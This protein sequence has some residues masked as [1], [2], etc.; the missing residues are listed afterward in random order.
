MVK[1]AE[2]PAQVGEQRR[3]AGVARE[4]QRDR[5]A[6]GLGLQHEAAPQC[7]AAVPRCSARPVVRR[8]EV[9]LHRAGGPWHDMPLPPVHAP[10]PG[11]AR[12]GHPAFD[13]Q[14]NDEQGRTAR[15]AG[16]R[17]HGSG[18]E[19]VVV[20]VADQD[21]VD[22]WQ[23]LD[24]QGCGRQPARTREG[25]RRG[26]R[27]EVRIGEDVEPRHLPQRGGVPEPGDRQV[28]PVAAQQIDVG[29]H[30][31]H[32]LRPVG[33]QIGLQP[34]P[35]PAQEAALL[36]AMGRGVQVDEAPGPM[37]RL[38]GIERVMGRR[39]SGQHDHQQR[40]QARKPPT[41]GCGGKERG[42]RGHGDLE[43]T[44][45]ALLSISAGSPPSDPGGKTRVHQFGVRAHT[46]DSNSPLHSLT[47]S[48]RG[49]TSPVAPTPHARAVSREVV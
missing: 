47:V 9:H 27:T 34:L 5:R 33:R 1:A 38:A 7:G 28:A 11:D 22:A 10:G 44:T 48:P 30:T 21:D 46:R 25:D 14:G 6:A 41:A 35:L 29:H 43:S 23:L 17:L 4:V 19:V 18:I 2:A 39:T 45:Q 24:R 15:L 3:M 37:V 8:H 20:V 13:A 26:P 32:A 40:E 12:V 49:S 31:W 42:D 36:V 16:Q